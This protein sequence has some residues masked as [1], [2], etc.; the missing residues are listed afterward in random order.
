MHLIF[1]FDGTLVDSF[2]CVVTLFNGLADD[3]SFSKVDLNEKQAL[4]HLSS[5]EL[6]T[7]FQ[8]PFYK[9]PHV[10]YKVRKSLF[11][12][13]TS[14][15]PFN[16]ITTVLNQ[17]VSQGFSLGIVSSNSEE[18]VVSWLKHHQLHQY[19]DFVHAGSS[20]FGKKRTL[21][22]VMKKNKI[23]EAFYIG[24]ETRDVDA[25]NQSNIYSMAVT[26]GFNSERILTT[27]QPH[28][29]ARVPEDILTLSVSHLVKTLKTPGN[30]KFE[31]IG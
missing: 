9:I 7:L 5:K 8:I 31:E 23:A 11:A 2:D 15:H 1:D 12:N 20:Y 3:Y 10:L 28:C 22:K 21:R 6:I 24:D 26:W 13:M 27:H 18:N 14:L 19:F 30:S 16:N 25:A 4:R 17:L 29:I